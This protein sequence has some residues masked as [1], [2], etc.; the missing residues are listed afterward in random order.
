MGT[1]KHISAAP[2]NRRFE[3]YQWFLGTV[4]RISLEKSEIRISKPE[5]I[6]NIK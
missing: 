6:T 3:E 1:P 4:G 5:T 2:F